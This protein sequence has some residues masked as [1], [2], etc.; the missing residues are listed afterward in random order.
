MAR[1]RRPDEQKVTWDQM[2]DRLV[3]DQG[4]ARKRFLEQKCVWDKLHESLS[5]LAKNRDQLDHRALRTTFTD[6]LDH[7]Y[8]VLSLAR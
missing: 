8:V 4:V 7:L 3:G 5:G 2:A 6:F 1:A